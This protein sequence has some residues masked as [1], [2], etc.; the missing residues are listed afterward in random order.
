[1]DLG[2]WKSG[3]GRPR[4][5]ERM[6]ME[7]VKMMNDVMRDAYKLLKTYCYFRCNQRWA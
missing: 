5:N 2:L 7:R 4:M 1:M 3:R 6:A